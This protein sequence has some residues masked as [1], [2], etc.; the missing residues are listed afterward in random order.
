M[1]ALLLS[2]FPTLQQATTNPCICRILLDAHGQVWVSL[3]W[4]HCFFFL[5]PSA[6][7]F[8]F[9]PSKSLFPQSWVSSG[10][11]MV[12]LMV[13]FS[14]KAYSIPKSAATSHTQVCCTQSTCLCGSPLLTCTATGDTQTKFCLSLCLVSRSW[15]AQ[16]L[17]ESYKKHAFSKIQP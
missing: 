5:G 13:T 8:L 11:S 14:K 7:K 3:L 1:H 12:G 2:L 15:C 4:G 17:I 16:G 9:V 10:I 6:H